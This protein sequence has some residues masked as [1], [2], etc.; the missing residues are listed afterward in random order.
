MPG[1]HRDRLRLFERL[2]L[3]HGAERGLRHRDLAPVHE[4]EAL[5]LERRV[6]AHAHADVQVAGHAVARRGGPATGEPEPLPVVDAGG[7]LH[8]D[9]SRRR[10]RARRRRTCGTGSGCAGRCPRT[11]WHGA[12]VTSWPSTE[13]RTWRTSPAP[14]QVS[15][16]VGCVP[17]S[18]PDPSHRSH[19]L[20]S[21]EL[22]RLRRAERGLDQVELDDRL[23]VRCPAAGPTPPPP[24][25]AGEEGVEEVAEP[26]VAGVW[27][28]RRRPGRRRRT[29]VA[30]APL[31]V[32][33]RLVGDG[34]LL[35]LRLGRR[36]PRVRVRVQLAGEARGTR[37]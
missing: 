35:E 19:S 21:V 10:A 22:E 27:A 28:H 5:T 1:G 7:Y 29:V 24:N 8:L 30:P 16:R 3:Q 2:D 12:A 33:Q 37:A 18:Q 26:E 25:V 9:V 31:R 11:P 13:R 23:G 17:G 15:Q 32:A 20:G 14:P 34:D 36:V 6:P 4:V